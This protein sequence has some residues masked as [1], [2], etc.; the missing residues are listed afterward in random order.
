MLNNVF[1]INMPYGIKG[2]HI[3]G[4]YF[5]NREYLPIG[6]TEKN[7]NEPNWQKYQFNSVA[8]KKLEEMGCYRMEI[9][10]AEEVYTQIFFYNDATNPVNNSDK[11]KANIC[12]EKY[13]LILK[14]ISRIE[15]N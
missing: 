4:W 12:W 5:F 15:R 3:K 7:D 6:E 14:T 10:E 1:R 11:K 9:N 13:L 2:N 8:I